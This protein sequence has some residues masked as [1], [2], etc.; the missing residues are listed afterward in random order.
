VF[1]DDDNWLAPDYLSIADEIM[2]DPTVGATGGQID[3]VFD[4]P[5]PTFAFSHGDCLALGIQGLCSEDVTQTRGFLWGAGL[6][7]RRSSLLEIYRC[8]YFPIRVGRTG[9]SLAQG[10]DSE[11]CWA[12][13]I[14]G[15]RLLYDERLKLRHYIPRE[16]LQLTYLRKLTDGVAMDKDVGR[17]VAGL[18]ELHRAG[19]GKAA[20]VNAMR[21]LRHL[22][23]PE[24]RRYRAHLFL[25]ACGWQ[26]RIGGIEGRICVAFESLRQSA[27]SSNFVGR[28][29]AETGQP[30]LLRPRSL[31][32]GDSDPAGRT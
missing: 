4:G 20:I 24:E 3:P 19:R 31:A 23:W 26:N 18:E 25:A 32:I 28:A 13:R 8:R 22:G 11:I 1:C 10:D 6:V 21:W 29:E 5:A 27:R 16:R 17:L 9:T 7:V 14:L 15:K 2:S 30:A 12:L